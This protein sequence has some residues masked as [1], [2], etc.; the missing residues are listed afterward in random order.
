MF[1]PVYVSRNGVLIPPAQACISVFNPAIY[2]A[3]GVYESM[4]V[5]HGI[6]FAQEAHLNRLAHSA[7]ILGLILPADLD[8]I[9]RWI[10][11]VLA[12]NNMADCTL[13]L[14]VLGGENDSESVAYI[15]PQPLVIYPPDYYTLGT[16][17]ITF[18]APRYLPEAKSLNTL[19]SF[20]AQRLARAAAVHE[21]LLHY[22]GFLTEGSNS[23]LFAVVDGVVYTPPRHT[24]LPGVTRDIVLKLAEEHDVPVREAPLPLAGMSQWTECF[25]T[26][27]SRHVMP[28]S[29]IDG[30]PVGD[31]RVGPLTRRIMALFEAYFADK[32]RNKKHSH[33]QLSGFEAL[34]GSPAPGAA[35]EIS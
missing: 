35:Q 3:Y 12:V 20:M 2:G 7:D 18:E 1:L 31:G 6:P 24:V 10:G 22:H 8:T 19:S 32:I 23:N 29:T 13:R 5:V 27:T 26:S 17:A 21:A 11:E 25:I 33:H 15:W 30:R 34:A 9:A 28:I 4:Q 16:T 14:F